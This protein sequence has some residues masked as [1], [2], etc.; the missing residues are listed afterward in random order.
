MKLKRYRIFT[1]VLVFLIAFGTNINSAVTQANPSVAVSNTTK[2]VLV[3]VKIP[4]VASVPT[5]KPYVS[6]AKFEPT[7][8]K[9]PAVSK[10]TV[11]EYIVKHS[12][13]LGI[14]PALGLTIAKLESNFDHNKRSAYGAVGVF[15]ILPSTARSM[16]YDAYHLNDNIKS[17]LTYYKKMYQK[18]GSMDLA[19]A[20]YN[21]GP[22]NVSK[23]KGVPPF[24]ET[25]RFITK[26]KTEYE[27]QKTNPD[28]AILKLQ[29][30]G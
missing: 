19:L 29:K 13:D 28:P 4:K 3:D 16:G 11:K 30:K 17:G 1:G 8:N 27:V 21:A 12:L 9:K 26:I 18:F 10:M 24:A 20:A 23:Y 22:A 14:D 6:K 2:T 7:S 25:K 5:P 15:Q